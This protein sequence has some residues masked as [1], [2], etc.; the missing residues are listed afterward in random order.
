MV[1][2]IIYSAI[3]AKP[4]IMAVYKQEVVLESAKSNLSND[5]LSK[6]VDIISK[7]LELFGIK[8][9]SIYP[10]FEKSQ[11]AINFKDEQNI[12]EIADLLTKKGKF[13]I[14]ETVDRTEILKRIGKSDSIYKYLQID[15]ISENGSINPIIGNCK[16][17][18][19]EKLSQYI[20]SGPF[21]VKIPTYSYFAWSKLSTENNEE[22]SLY[23]LKTGTD[24]KSSLDSISVSGVNVHEEGSDNYSLYLNF[25]PETAAKWQ[26]ITK[27]NVQKPLAMIVDHH[28]YFAPVVQEEMEGG[29]CAITGN[30]T[31]NEMKNL[32]AIV[33]NGELPSGF[34]IK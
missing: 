23:Y 31:E 29:K 18:N 27:K 10:I 11:I 26:S 33:K 15:D 30:F 8:L 13:E 21:Q 1:S 20:N 16:L 4:K 2:S 32:A 34:R 17:E 6:S 7:R 22:L 3:P 24:N 9:F 5:E 12:V 19:V 25:A 14:S 28:V